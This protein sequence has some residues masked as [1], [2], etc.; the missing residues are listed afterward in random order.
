MNIPP[1]LQHRIVDFLISLPSIHD[2]NSQRSLIYQAGLD[3]ELQGQISFDKPAMQFALFLV[4]TLIKYG[5][6]SDGRYAIEAILEAAK[7]F[8]GQDRKIYCETLINELHD[9]TIEK[10]DTPLSDD[11]PFLKKR[12][13][14]VD[15]K[16][17]PKLVTE[18]RITPPDLTNQQQ[19]Q[20]TGDNS[21]EI[22]AFKSKLLDYEL[23]QLGLPSL[24]FHRNNLESEGLQLIR[25]GILPVILIQGLPGYGKTVLL[26]ELAKKIGHEFQ[27]TLVLN[28]SGPASIE[29][30]YVIE[31][32]NTF[33]N[34]L[35]R[36]ID[37]EILRKQSTQRSLQILIPQM[38]DLHLL[39]L[40]DAV[41]GVPPGQI[42]TFLQFLT[43]TPKNR[44]IMTA[45][46]RIVNRSNAHILHV[47]PLSNK[48]TADFVEQYTKSMKIGV[49][50]KDL[51]EKLPNNIKEHPQALSM[52]LANLVDIPF[53]LLVM[54]SFHDDT[55]ILQQ[56][57][58]NILLAIDKEVLTCLVFMI[59]LDDLDFMDTLKIL[60]INP[61][62]GLVN[63]INLL[64]EKSLIYRH[65]NSYRVPSIIHEGVLN[66]IPD[67]AETILNQIGYIL[68]LKIN[69]MHLQRVSD[70]FDNLIP[71]VVT[72]IHHFYQMRSYEWVTKLVIDEFLEFINMRGFW[73]EYWLILRISFDAAKRINQLNIFSKIGF[74]IARKSLQIHDIDT[75]SQV[76][77]DVERVI[78]VDGNTMEHAEFWSHKAL[79]TELTGYTENA[80]EEL[81]KSLQIRES[82]YDAE[83]IAVI[84]KLLGNIHLRLK[85]SDI[86]RQYYE[87]A[88]ISINENTSQ[89][90]HIIEV[91]TS[92]AL[93]DLIDNK[94]ES[95]ESTLRK[96]I[97][98]CKSKGY[99][100]GLS[101]AYYN[102][103][104][105]LDRQ[106]RVAEAF[107][108]AEIA[109]K[110]ALKTDKD[111][112]LGSGIL[113]WRLKNLKGTSCK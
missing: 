37:T 58:K 105:V 27:Y 103:A 89:F 66:L 90:K 104:L 96:V 87:S 71:I 64:L 2:N 56:L 68:E 42:E 15:A 91:E 8:V 10:A 110:E 84:Q 47:P 4:S 21:F 16:Y 19:L 31:E 44:L 101:R 81:L 65:E 112:I 17:D 52:I 50:I 20:N 57:A 93:C 75:G 18:I 39:L 102:L 107:Y 11:I 14:I 32:I 30:S 78:G 28:F 13:S 9:Y 26:G 35:G 76:L 29:P 69:R 43:A 3:T 34:K 61:P 70:H 59:V 74:R 99:L 6:L 25:E 92:L 73:K 36:G 38:M 49:N 82:L 22:D 108:Y 40:L 88:L 7:N 46:Y 86:A 100:A 98:N 55:L 63:S 72:I 53:E 60:E 54:Q 77:S 45:R 5:K 109:S 23:S 113:M 51:L 1:R 67:I 12:N 79:F 62:K 33:L 48:E 41:D 97:Q 24:I 85:E 106:K 94:L 83:G 80:K 95:A 111:I